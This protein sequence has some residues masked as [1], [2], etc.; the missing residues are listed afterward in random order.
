MSAR[1]LDWRV[2]PDADAVAAAAI[3]I[4]AAAAV[5]AIGQRGA[6]RLVLAGPEGPFAGTGWQY[7]HDFIVIYSYQ[8]RAYYT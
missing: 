8:T 5:D 2:L 4:I 1:L 6:F 7:F 3:R